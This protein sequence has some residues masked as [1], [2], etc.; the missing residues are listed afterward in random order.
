MLKL[1]SVDSVFHDAK[2]T[3]LYRVVMLRTAVFSGF[4][5]YNLQPVEPLFVVNFVGVI[6]YGIAQ[7]LLHFLF[8][9]I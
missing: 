4:V 7:Y 1:L 5:C 6:F 3:L 2:V 8:P 9:A